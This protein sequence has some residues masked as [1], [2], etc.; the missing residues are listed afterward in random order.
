MEKP[1]FVPNTVSKA[2]MVSSEPVE[3][4]FHTPVIAIAKAVAEQ[5]IIVSINTSK[6]PHSPCLTGWSVWAVA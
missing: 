6:M 4:D 1:I 2:D 5:M 3:P